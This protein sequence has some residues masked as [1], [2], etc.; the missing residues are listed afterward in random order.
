MSST[1]IKSPKNENVSSPQLRTLEIKSPSSPVTLCHSKTAKDNIVQLNKLIHDWKE[2]TLKSIK[3]IKSIYQI[4]AKS[5]DDE[6]DWITELEALFISAE[7]AIASYD[8][9]VCS[10]KIILNK[11]KALTKLCDENDILL[12]TCTAEST[13][14]IVQ[15]IVER[16]E[17]ELC[18]KRVIFGNIAHTADVS[19]LTMYTMGWEKEVHIENVSV[20]ILRINLETK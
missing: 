1:P 14:H 11:F 10:M 3:I 19:K 15:K 8:N 18:V 6:T 9:I 7:E 16:Y 20:D 17:K 12:I 13:E 2:L 4:K 5:F